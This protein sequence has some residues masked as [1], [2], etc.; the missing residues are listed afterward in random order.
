MRMFCTTI[1]NNIN[2]YF[3]KDPFVTFLAKFCDKMQATMCLG[4]TVAQVAIRWLLQTPPVT[5]VI[6][7]ATKIHQLEENIGAVGWKLTKE[8][9]RFIG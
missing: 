1:Y 9:V 3:Q 8:E 4:K 5:S 6:I 2:S 7:G